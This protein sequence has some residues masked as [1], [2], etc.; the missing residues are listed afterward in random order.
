MRLLHR[1]FLALAVSCSA[2]AQ[3][4]TISTYAGGALPVNIPGASASLDYPV[5]A[6]AVDGAGN[7]F[8]TLESVVLRLDAITGILSLVA[9]NWTYGFSSDNGPATSAQLD[10]VVGV[11]VDSAGNLYIADNGNRIRK[12]SGGVI[13]TV[14]GNGVAARGTPMRPQT[15]SCSRCA[16]G[17]A[18]R[19][20]SSPLPSALAWRSASKEPA[21]SIRWT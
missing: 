11:A 9:G 15:T 7:V 16:R 14:A 10:F 12:V 1:V 4:Y 5:N 2:P 3:S 20:T 19:A 8:F 17:I 6:V 18:C 13:M 21:Q